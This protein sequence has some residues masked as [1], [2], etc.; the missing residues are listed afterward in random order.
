MTAEDDYEIYQE[1]LK[2]DLYGFDERMTAEDDYEIYQEM[3]KEDLYGFDERDWP[4]V[5]KRRRKG[6]RKSSPKGKVNSK[7]VR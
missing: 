3:L 2:E 6:Y 5:A 7:V 4:A 1:M